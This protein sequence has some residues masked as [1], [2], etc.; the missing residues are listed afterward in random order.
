[1]KRIR[2]KSLLALVTVVAIYSSFDHLV[3]GE[4]NASA[5]SS[6]RTNEAEV[7]PWSRLAPENGKPFNDPFAKLTGQ[8]LADLGY[9]VRVR[10]LI[11]DKK[12]ESDGEDAKA[13]TQLARE[14]EKQGVDIRW[15]MVQR[16]RVRQIRVL[17]VEQLS[18]TIASSFGDR[19]IVMTGYVMPITAD[20]G[21]VTEF[22]LV[23]TVAACSHEAAPPP[24]QVVYVSTD[25]GFAAPDKATPVRVTGIIKA[26]S[27]ART[28]IS[29]SGKTT[30]RSAY[31]MLS[32]AVETYA[33]AHR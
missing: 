32:P 17:Q 15:L 28:K 9:V 3:A 6:Q 19:E 33:Q 5:I 18:K 10:Q 8:Q 24:L 1:M 29:A 4:T 20:R 25:E 2:T 16:E 23:P 14:L 11:A 12:I 31:T 7:I 27:K 26:S 21:Q 22:F 13:A 30:V